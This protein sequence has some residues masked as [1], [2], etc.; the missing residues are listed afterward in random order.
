M[1]KLRILET[2]YSPFGQVFYYTGEFWRLSALPMAV[3]YGVF[4]LLSILGGEEGALSSLREG[5]DF[6]LILLC[7]AIV[8]TPFTVAWHRI[9]L[10]GAGAGV[11]GLAY[12]PRE[13]RFLMWGIFLALLTSTTLFFVSAYIVGVHGQVRGA[14]RHSLGEVSLAVLTAPALVVVA[15]TVIVRLYLIL[16][17]ICLDRRSSLDEAW[18]LTAGNGLR[19]GISALLLT[20]PT[21][22]MVFVSRGAIGLLFDMVLPEAHVHWPKTAVLGAIEM[23]AVFLAAALGA[24]F[25][26]NAYQVLL[27][28]EDGAGTSSLFS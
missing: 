24:T 8:V 9:V 20:V 12:G 27:E 1:G 4:A 11:R 23:V 21:A 10:L 13:A 16:P 25:L 28:P 5:F 7:I 14:A 22:L 2:A 3:Y 15:V 17:A 19:L 6:V 26:S 18:R